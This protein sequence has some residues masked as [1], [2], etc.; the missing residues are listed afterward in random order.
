MLIQR[1][2]LPVNGRFPHEAIGFGVKMAIFEK[3]SK[4]FSFGPLIIQIRKLFLGQTV[5]RLRHC[6]RVP[7][8][9]EYP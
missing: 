3:V 7:P 5:N 8:N 2:H 1:K 6:G 9:P 4:G